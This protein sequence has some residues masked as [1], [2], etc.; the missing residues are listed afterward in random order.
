MTGTWQS[1]YAELKDFVA[2]HPAIKIDAGCIIIPEDVRPEFYRLFD[3]VRLTFIESRYPASLEKNSE[4]GRHYDEVTRRLADT[5]GLEKI[6][7]LSTGNDFRIDPVNTL[8]RLLM[9]PLFDLLKGNTDMAGFDSSASAAVG[10]AFRGFFSEGYQLWGTMA[11]MDVMGPQKLWRAQVEDYYI[12]PSSEDPCH[13]EGI[14]DQVVPKPAETKKL[15]FD[16]SPYCN[17]LVPQAVI[18]SARLNTYAGFCPGFYEARRKAQSVSRNVEWFRIKDISQKHA[19]GRMWPDLAIY[20]DDRLDELSLIADCY[21]MA[22]PDILV[23]FM[24]DADWYS[25]GRLESVKRHQAM[26]KPRLGTFVFCREEVPQAAIKELE[27]VPA[28][29]PAGQSPAESAGAQAAPAAEPPTEI[30][31]LYVNYDLTRMEPVV[32]AVLKARAASKE[33]K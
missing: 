22:R 12:D 32:E 7:V 33:V 25:S 17:F 18:R 11:L 9:D 15:L 13:Q 10:G 21:Q 14:R 8:V 1:A 30:R 19:G 27:P 6:E 2:A 5:L 26:L 3:G 29:G 31:L 20:L 4:L 23:E 16:K 24:E 28:P